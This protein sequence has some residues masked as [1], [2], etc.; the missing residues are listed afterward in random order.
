MQPLFDRRR[1]LGS[2]GLLLAPAFA[3]GQEKLDHKAEEQLKT[4]KIELP[5]VPKPT[6]ATLVPTVRVG[7]VLYVSGHTSVGLDGKPIVGKV[8]KDLDVKQGAEAARVVGLRILS[9]VRAEL[10]SLDKVVRLVKTL[11]MVNCTP[12]FTQQPQVI[13]GCSDLMV[14]IFGA[15]A[16]KGTRSAVGMNSLPGGVAVEIEAIFQ[17]RG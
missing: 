14:Q 9:V 5:A 4:L 11:G 10:G 12:D 2:C 6:G 13:N 15:G 8:G 3:V 17:V 7:D 1:F 16:G